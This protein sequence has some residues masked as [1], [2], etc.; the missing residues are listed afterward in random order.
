VSAAHLKIIIAQCPQ[1]EKNFKASRSHSVA[2][3][4]PGW[5]VMTLFYLQLFFFYVLKIKS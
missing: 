4:L 3:Q 5:F 1:K 2:Y